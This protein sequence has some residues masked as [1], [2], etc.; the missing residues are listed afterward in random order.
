MPPVRR[1]H[2]RPVRRRERRLGELERLVEDPLVQLLAP[3]V[4]RLELAGD[5][6]RPGR[7]VRQQQREP[8]GRL[9][10]TA[11]GVQAGGED[12]ADVSRLDRVP[13]EPCHRHQGPQPRPVRIGEHLQAVPH[14]DAVLPD[15]RDHI[16]DG[17]QRH[18]IEEV[19]RQVGGLAE[20]RHQGLGELEGDSG[21]AQVLVL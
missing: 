13:G 9:P 8:V 6:R 21:A 4:Q 16:R 12:E 11:G 17:R 18:I 15:Q 10:D 19:E 5:R 2:E 14:Q 1:E 20:C 7:I 3:G